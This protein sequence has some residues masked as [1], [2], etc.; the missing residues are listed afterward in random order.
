MGIG[1]YNGIMRE[2][3][4]KG[5]LQGVGDLKVNREGMWAETNT[6]GKLGTEVWERTLN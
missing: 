5:N 6:G 1:K 2:N 3:S 4:N